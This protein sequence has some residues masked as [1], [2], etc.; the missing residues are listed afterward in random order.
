MSKQSIPIKDMD[1]MQHIRNIYDLIGASDSN[2]L[3]GFDS[4]VS[5]LGNISASDNQKIWVGSTKAYEEGVGNGTITNEM[6]CCIDDDY[7][8]APDSVI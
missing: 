8:P 3:I 5:G 2:G 4:I 7:I 1:V 6:I